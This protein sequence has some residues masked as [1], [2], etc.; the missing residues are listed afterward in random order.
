MM[1]IDTHCHVDLQSHF[2]DYHQ[3][4]ERAGAVGVHDMVMAGVCRNGW[5]R[6]LELSRKH[7][8]LHAA[9]GLHPM[10]L[11]R[12]HHSDLDEL[13][14]LAGT[15]E[16]VAI[17]EV[18]LDYYIEDVDHQAQQQLFES[19]V[20]IAA[21]AGLPLL[22]HVRKAHDKVLSTL[23]RKRFTHGG[24][25]HAFNGSYQQASHFIKLGFV[26]GICGT[27]TYDRARKI[28]KVARDLPSDSL[29]L[30][31]DAPDIPLATHRPGRNSPEFLP[32]VLTALAQLRGEQ[33][34]LLARQTTQNA[35]RVLAFR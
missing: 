33:T 3:V 14:R 25:V 7:C 26:I 20:E 22:L 35:R 27:V 2:P 1:L 6:M 8:Q 30:E 23:R 21:Q 28:R 5:S 11:A 4:L 31:T 34:A 13:A 16:L 17:G 18:G 29:V 19:Q 12:H 24:I 10:Y 15:G 9:P 32:E